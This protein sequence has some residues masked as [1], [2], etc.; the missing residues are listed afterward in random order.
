MVP[1]S[2]IPILILFSHLRLDL[3]SRFTLGFPTKTCMRVSLMHVHALPMSS[4]ISRIAE[5]R[6]TR[7]RY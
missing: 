6:W 3:P 5:V 1:I 7:L 2:L 4:Q